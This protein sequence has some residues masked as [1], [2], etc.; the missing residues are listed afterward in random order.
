M[1]LG[2]HSHAFL[3][4][5]RSKIAVIRYVCVFKVRKYHQFSKV[6]V[7]VCT[8][9]GRL[10][11]SSSPSLGIPSLFNLGHFDAYGFRFRRKSFIFLASP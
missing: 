2:T 10:A 1:S 3:C 6:V 11:V 5:P 4:V 9:T 8:P 7:P